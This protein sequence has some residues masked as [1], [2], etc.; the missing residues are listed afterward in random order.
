M[1]NETIK[2]NNDYIVSRMSDAVRKYLPGAAA[3]SDAFTQGT[4]KPVSDYYKGLV[5]DPTKLI[6]VDNNGNK[7]INTEQLRKT[8]RFS[9][10]FQMGTVDVST[11]AQKA[12]MAIRPAHQKLIEDA[13]KKK[14]WTTVKKIIDEM[15]ETDPYKG[16]MKSL[17]ADK[18]DDTQGRITQKVLYHG[19]T[20]EAA[21]IIEKK[22]FDIKKSADGSIWFTDNLAKIEG[23]EVAAAGKGGV[24]KRIIDE[25]KLKLGGWAETDK[26]GMD[27]LINMGYDGLK[28]PDKGEITYQIFNPNKLKK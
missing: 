15:P 2:K 26:Y 9:T 6:E 13:A 5:P 16:S 24:I 25:S 18:I 19:T 12:A 1:I 21:K 3:I 17:F 27:E 28:L 7:K 14:D 20:P 23:G 4:F 8:I 11:P 22:G 10:S